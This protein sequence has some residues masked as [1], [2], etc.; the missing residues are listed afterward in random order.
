MNINEPQFPTSNVRK[1]WNIK[2]DPEYT[3]ERVD[4]P[5]GEATREA[6]RGWVEPSGYQAHKHGEPTYKATAFSGPDYNEGGALESAAGLT[7]N[8]AWQKAANK[9]ETVRV[10]KIASGERRTEAEAAV[11]KYSTPKPR[12]TIKID[13]SK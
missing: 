11:G 3:E 4:R 1:L 13:S 10:N 8:K 5:S 2:H 9:A 6:P 12:Q 7:P